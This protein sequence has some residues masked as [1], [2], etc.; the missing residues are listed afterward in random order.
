ML[1]TASSGV[2]GRSVSCDEPQRVRLVAEL[3]A[4]LLGNR[5]EHPQ[6]NE[7]VVWK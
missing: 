1:K 2:L 3:P 5:F 7:N 4:A 6:R